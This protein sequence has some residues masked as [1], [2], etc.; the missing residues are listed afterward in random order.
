MKAIKRFD[1]AHGVRLV[2]FAVHWVKAEIHEFVLKNWRIVKMATTKAQRK[3]FFNLRSHKKRLGW[4]TDQEVKDV[5]ETLGVTPKDVM[6]MEARLHHMDVAFDA[7]TDDDDTAAFAP[8]QYLEDHS[9]NPLLQLE[10]Q[11]RA[12]LG[13]QGLYHALDVLDDRARDILQRRWLNEDKATLHELAAEY[14]VSAERI[15]QLEQQAMKKLKAALTE[16]T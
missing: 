6:Q 1:P 5:A 2:T 10:N 14:K 3:L 7:P 9:G 12:M 8:S 15:R 4:F 13:Q 11:D 16:A